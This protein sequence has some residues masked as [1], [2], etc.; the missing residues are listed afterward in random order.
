MVGRLVPPS[1]SVT[2]PKVSPILIDVLAN[3]V[4]SLRSATAAL[5]SLAEPD[6]DT[7]QRRR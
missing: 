5:R 3:L 1:P 7:L 4:K 6:R 2:L